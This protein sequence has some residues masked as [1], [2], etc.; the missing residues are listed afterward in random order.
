[1]KNRAVST[2]LAAALVAAGALT[3]G[4]CGAPSQAPATGAAVRGDTVQLVSAG[5]AGA[6][7]TSTTPAAG[8]AKKRSR[9]A[10][11]LHATW[12]TGDKAGAVTHQAVRGEV[13]AVSGT[14]VTVRAED[15][16]SMSFSVTADT[17]VR[18]GSGK[19]GADAKIASVAVGDRARVVG[20]GAD[21][22]QASRVTFRSAKA[23]TS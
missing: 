20:A 1:M 10:H 2:T 16:F 19:T 23:Q 8:D 11:S 9:L 21:H 4:A 22:P 7:A 17:K 12:V 14:Q 15:G 5:T 18:Q 6:A 13:T 3:V